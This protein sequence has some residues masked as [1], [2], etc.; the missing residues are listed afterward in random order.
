[1]STARAARWNENGG[2]SV[3]VAHRPYN[4]ADGRTASATLGA[5]CAAAPARADS[6][7]YLLGMPPDQHPD[8]APRLAADPL[9][10]RSVFVAPHRRGKPTDAVLAAGIAA[11]LDEPAGWCPFCAGNERLT[12]AAVVTAPAAAGAAWHARIIPNRYPIA[13]DLAAVDLAAVDSAGGGRG[14]VP[15]PRAAHGVHDV[16]IESPRHERTI[17]AVEPAAWREVWELCR[18]RLAMVADRGDLAWGTI[19]KNSGPR[20]GASLEHVHSQLVAVDVVPPVMEAELAAVR[21]RKDAFANLLADARATGRIVAAAADLV[22]L[23]PPAPRQP[24]ETWI[25]PTAPERHFHAA[26]AE[27]VAALADLTRDLVARLER[28]VPDSDYNWWLHQAPFCR[29]AAD[30]ARTASWHWHLEILPR[31]A[32]VAGFEL[33][34]G[35]HITTMSAAD[36]ARL[37]R[38]AAGASASG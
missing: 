10:G 7:A 3:R 27:R 28:L 33:G 24:F 22:A 31:V 9:S 34:T 32:E 4:T 20:A 16:V 17:L 1:M 15:G 5:E 25:M 14:A 26:A 2:P 21:D 23:V 8:P 13:V 36:S 29:T 35:C 37:L 30:A 38:D 12:P 11:A 19:F 6:R 18:R